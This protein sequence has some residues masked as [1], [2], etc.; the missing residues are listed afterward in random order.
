MKQSI[1]LFVAIVFALAVVGCVTAAPPATLTPSPTTIPTLP[2]PTTAKPT[3]PPIPEPTRPLIPSPTRP[4]LPD[5]TPVLPPPI[6]NEPTP[7]P[8]GAPVITDPTLLKFINEAKIDLSVRANVLPDEIKLISADPVEWR[9]GSLGCP[10]LGVMYIQVITP[11]YLIVLQAAGK[12]WNY[13]AGSDRVF[14]CDK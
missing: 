3:L 11:G 8:G 5:L 14:W 6:G 2:I 9:D 4:S 13:H 10:K 7:T 1:V 12:Q